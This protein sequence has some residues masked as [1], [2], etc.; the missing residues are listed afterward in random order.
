MEDIKKF[1]NYTEEERDNGLDSKGK[2]ISGGDRYP[3]LA[4]IARQISKD[5]VA[6]INTEADK[7]ESKM[8]YKSQFILEELIKIL[9]ELV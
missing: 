1:E 3:E 5:V 2:P 6:K 7:V 4:Y 9:E 8:P